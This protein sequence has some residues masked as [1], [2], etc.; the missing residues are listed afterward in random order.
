ME[1]S[2]EILADFDGET[3]RVRT[4]GREGQ[5]GEWCSLWIGYSWLC[6]DRVVGCCVRGNETWGFIKMEGFRSFVT[7]RQLLKGRCYCIELDMYKK[8]EE[9]LN[10]TS[11]IWNVHLPMSGGQMFLEQTVSSPI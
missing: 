11:S 4:S 6:R 10:P 8:S 7:D 5:V 1:C 9:I 2:S 3:E